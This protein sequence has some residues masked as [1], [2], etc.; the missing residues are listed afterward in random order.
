MMLY[1]SGGSED[2]TVC[3]GIVVR[4][5]VLIVIGEMYR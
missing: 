4:V 5:Q 2:D 3:G 1:S